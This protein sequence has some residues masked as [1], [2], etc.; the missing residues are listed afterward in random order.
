MIHTAKSVRTLQAVAMTLGIALLLW[1]TGLPTLFRFAEASSITNASDTLS[2]SAPSLASNH[3]IA[4]ELPNGMLASANFTITFAS[5]FDTSAVTLSD[6]DLTVNTVDQTLAEG[7]SGA[8]SWGVTGLTTDS[9]TFQAPTDGGT[10]S[11]SD[12]VIKIGSNASFGGAGTIR[13]VNPSAT[14]SY[15]IT[16]AG[17]MQDAGEM[18]VAI[19][20]QVTVSA[21]VDTSLTF[22]VTGVNSSSTVNGSATTTIATTTATTLPFGN[23]PIGV[24][25]TLAHDLAVTTNAKNGYTVTVQQTGALQSSTGATIDGFIDG[26]NTTVPAAWQAPSAQIAS[27]LTYGHWGI[28]SSDHA[29]TS[30][31]FEFSND[32]WVSGS[33]TPIAIMGATTPADG[34]TAGIGT[35]RVGYQI[36]ISAL[37]EAGDDY[38]TTLRYVVTPTF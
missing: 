4:F 11:S 20:D 35:A 38:N 14:T 22:A 1:S 13:I 9:I 31:A 37:Q 19:V 2:N 7:A 36:Q 27:S 8:G 25:R 16:I 5:Q 18:R 6:V 10:A 21:S 26:T 33:T 12:M 15:P 24:S 23:L 3:T 28:T 30:R 17:T 32:T 29:S 34:L